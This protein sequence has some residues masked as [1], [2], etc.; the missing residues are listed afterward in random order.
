MDLRIKY[1][2]DLEAQMRTRYAASLRRTLVDPYAPAPSKRAAAA[3]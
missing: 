2:P 3:G 1:C